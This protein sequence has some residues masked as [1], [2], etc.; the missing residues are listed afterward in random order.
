MAAAME[1]E[2]WRTGG[3]QQRRAAALWRE[4]KRAA[5]RPWRRR[6]RGHAH[7][8]AKTHAVMA[9]LVGC[10]REWRPEEGVSTR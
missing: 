9:E 7:G 3:G 10:G 8:R 1:K 2:E 4:R 5:Q 6:W